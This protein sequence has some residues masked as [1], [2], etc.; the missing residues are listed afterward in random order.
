M[1]IEDVDPHTYLNHSPQQWYQGHVSKDYYFVDVDGKCYRVWTRSKKVEF[2][3]S[4]GDHMTRNATAF[5]PSSKPSWWQPVSR[6]LA[7]SDGL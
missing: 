6:W 3:E 2:W 4:S 1:I 5:I 7:V